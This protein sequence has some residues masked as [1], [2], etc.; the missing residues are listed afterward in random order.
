MKEGIILILYQLS[1]LSNEALKFYNLLLNIKNLGR[2]P[3]FFNL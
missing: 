2:I 1:V 3:R